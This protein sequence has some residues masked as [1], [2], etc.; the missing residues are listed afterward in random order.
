MTVPTQ[1]SPPTP[2]QMKKRHGAG[3][4]ILIGGGL[5]AFLVWISA[6]AA[7]LSAT[8]G[9]N[10][11]Q[12]PSSSAPSNTG[13]PTAARYNSVAD[14]R[15]AAVKAGYPCPNWEPF[16]RGRTKHAQEAGQCFD[17]DVFSIYANDADRGDQLALSMS[18]AENLLVGPNWLINIPGEHVERVQAGIGGEHVEGQVEESEPEPT[19]PPMAKIGSYTTARCGNMSGRVLITFDDWNDAD[20]YRATRTGAYLEAR[21]V[22]AAFFLTGAK[23][24]SYP[25]IVA[26][27]RQQGHWVANHSYTHPHLT[28]L[29]DGQLRAEISNGTKSNQLRPPY[30]DWDSRVTT[31]AS[32]LGYKI[33][34]ATVNTKDWQQFSGSYRSISSIRSMVRNAPASAK[35]SG[36]IIGHLHTNFPDALGGIIDDLHSQGFLLCR[37]TGPVA[38][39]MPYP[40]SCKP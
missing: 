15:D 21:K 19:K 27:L 1:L 39:N 36:V 28:E 2:P 4:W 35:Q 10:A 18:V 38:A 13:S 20:P 14:L 8:T 9:G 5:V 3:F 7:I 11:A 34:W 6:C 12:P 24:E 23:A 16:E 33:C 31:I 22:R 30:G 37:N 29:T 17:E 26:T 25:D 32:S 40:L